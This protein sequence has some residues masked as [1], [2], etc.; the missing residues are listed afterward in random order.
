MAPCPHVARREGA[1]CGPSRCGG[2]RA[3]RA[4]W[5]SLP[6]A[7]GA[8]L[9]L[10]VALRADR[11]RSVCANQAGGTFHRSETHE[12]SHGPGNLSLLVVAGL[13]G[14][15][16]WRRGLLPSEGL[17]PV[18]RERR[19]P[20]RVSASRFSVG[21]GRGLAAADSRTGPSIRGMEKCRSLPS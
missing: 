11:G 6:L 13:G 2:E 1:E 20:W 15:L 3:R 17:R 16:C 18:S 9:R 5:A 8:G 12:L 19:V 21:W 10:T 14:R 7:C 4:R